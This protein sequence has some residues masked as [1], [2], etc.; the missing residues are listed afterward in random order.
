MDVSH[1]FPL[2]CGI[3]QTQRNS[4][5]CHLYFLK[6]PLKLLGRV[7]VVVVS[8]SLCRSIEKEKKRKEWGSA[9]PDE[10]SSELSPA[11]EMVSLL[12]DAYGRHY[13]RERER[14]FEPL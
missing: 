9:Q 11:P 6:R 14:G 7:V 4:Y 8:R 13:K 10:N 5:D 12:A 3:A 1:C 2:Y